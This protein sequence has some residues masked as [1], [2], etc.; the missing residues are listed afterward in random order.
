MLNDPGDDMLL[1]LAVEAQCDSIVTHNIKDFVGASTF[2]IDVI[3]PVEFLRKIGDV[4]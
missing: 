4:P 1:E 2:G 3:T